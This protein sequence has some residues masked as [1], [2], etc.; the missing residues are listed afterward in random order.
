MKFDSEVILASKGKFRQETV[1]A[2]MKQVRAAE[3]WRSHLHL[4]QPVCWTSDQKTA[5]LA[6]SL[7]C[8][9]WEGF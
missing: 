7:S 9:H 6:S 3:F 5:V 2:G 1:S 8:K 4:R